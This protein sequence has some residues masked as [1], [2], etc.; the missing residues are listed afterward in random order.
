MMALAAH[1]MGA[2]ETAHMTLEC[3]QV[4]VNHFALDARGRD[5]VGQSRIAGTAMAAGV[6][7]D[8][9]G[10]RQSQRSNWDSEKDD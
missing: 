7:P 2:N 6:L 8:W 9:V 5:A 1:A 3:R 4:V 10:P